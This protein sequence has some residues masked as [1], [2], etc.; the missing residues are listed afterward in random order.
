MNLRL[1]VGS[2]ERMAARLSLP[3]GGEAVDADRELILGNARSISEGLW[4]MARLTQDAA[5]ALDGRIEDEDLDGMAEA[6]EV[7]DANTTAHARIGLKASK[8]SG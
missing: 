1:A 5:E 7:R 8:I 3:E 2:D 6:V 4:R